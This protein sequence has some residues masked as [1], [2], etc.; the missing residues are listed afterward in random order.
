MFF[1][2]SQIWG[3]PFRNK[4]PKPGVEFWG[5]VKINFTEPDFASCAGRR[6]RKGKSQNSQ[7]WLSVAAYIMFQSKGPFILTTI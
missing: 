5:K 7:Y 1:Y 2:I 6:L 4:S 3:D